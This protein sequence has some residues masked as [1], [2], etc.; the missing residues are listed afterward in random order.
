[1][2]APGE[3]DRLYRR[4]SLLALITVIYN[5][6]E[7]VVSVAFG[8]EDESLS[9]FGFGMDSFVEVVSALGVWHMIR[10]IRHDEEAGPDRFER[11]A[12]RITGTG[13]AVLAA[14]LILTSA[15]S[16]IQGH[17]P[18]ATFWGIV[19]GSVSIVTMLA[20]IQMKKK[21]GRA[22]GSPAIVADAHC[23]RACL[24]LSVVLLVASAGYELTGIGGL[25]AIGALGIALLCIKEGLEA[26]EKASRL[27]RGCSCSSE[28]ACG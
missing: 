25:D 28:D 11:R 9:L 18:E 15:F 22:L 6:I 2:T 24:Y 7:G 27:T 3:R 1:M 26:F 13:F 21:V 20:L 10:R 5:V 16:L 23:N 14:G 19:V 17:R 4:A 12:L 8:V